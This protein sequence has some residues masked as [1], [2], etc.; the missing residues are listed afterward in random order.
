MKRSAPLLRKTPL[1]RGG[2][3]K[4]GAPLSRGG[5]LRRSQ[6]RCHRTPSDSPKTT[7]L[8]T[9]QLQQL[10]ER[11]SEE[12]NEYRALCDIFLFFF[13]KCQCPGCF[14]PS[15]DVHHKAGRGRFYLRVETWLAVCRECHD[16]IH[17]NGTE[18]RAKG[19][20]VARS[21]HLLAQLE[22]GAEP[23]AA[24][25]PGVSALERNG[26]F[27]E[28]EEPRAG[29]TASAPELALQQLFRLAGRRPVAVSTDGRELHGLRYA[30]LPGSVELCVHAGTWR[31]LMMRYTPAA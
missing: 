4:R 14:A 9:A 6:F 13:P 8:R 16:W 25:A 19:L 5:S 18:A 3:L 7:L 30:F 26:A 29:D 24:T 22:A 27:D 10:S 23:F 2:P 20:L 31:P 1:A 15:E 28:W 12:R 17:H 11:R 21:S